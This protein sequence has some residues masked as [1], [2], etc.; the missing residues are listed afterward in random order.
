MAK[1]ILKRK[2]FDL[3]EAGEN[4]LGGV[5]GAASKVTGNVG[6]KAIGAVKGAQWGASAF[7]LPGAAMGLLGGWA[8]MGE[9]S[10]GLKSA[11]NSMNGNGY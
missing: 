5:A 9:V 2:T 10:K 4:I 11:Q 3:K 1:Y 7:G 6:A 8:G